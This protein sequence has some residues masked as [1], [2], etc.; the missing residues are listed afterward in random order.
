VEGWSVL[1]HLS[2]LAVAAQHVLGLS[3]DFPDDWSVMEDQPLRKSLLSDNSSTI[4]D[5]Q[6]PKKQTSDPH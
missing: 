2:L 1:E 3:K 5:C 6:A 4:R